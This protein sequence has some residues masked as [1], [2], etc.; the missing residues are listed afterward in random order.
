MIMDKCS[1]PIT[2][3]FVLVQPEGVARTWSDPEV[4]RLLETLLRIWADSLE[5]EAENLYITILK[6]G[7][8]P[9]S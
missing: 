7:I 5:G 4:K 2:T 6:P 1:R 8:T 9:S 3:R